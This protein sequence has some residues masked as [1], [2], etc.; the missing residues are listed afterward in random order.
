[1]RWLLF[2]LALAAC[3]GAVTSV[4]GNKNTNSLT[5]TDQD[6]LCLDTY[7]YVKSSISV[8]DIAK[9]ECGF[10]TT[11]TDPSSCAQTYQTC[12]TTAEANAQQISWPLAPDCTGFDQSV[13]ACNTTVAEYTKCLQEEVDALKSLESSFPLCSTAQEQA[14]G[15]QAESRLTTD[16]LAL[17]QTCQI[18]FVPAGSGSSGGAPNGG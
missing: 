17:M 2:A 9:L 15:I 6:Q 16:C 4:D 13:A 10:Q 18:T 1:M 5:P 12:L 8:D 14:A 3:G 7:N 11:S